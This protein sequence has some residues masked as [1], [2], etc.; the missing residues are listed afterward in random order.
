VLGLDYCQV[1]VKMQSIQRWPDD[2][3]LQDLELMELSALEAW[4][5]QNE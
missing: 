3:L 4:D 2:L 5:P 1:K